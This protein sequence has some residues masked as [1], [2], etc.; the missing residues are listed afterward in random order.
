MRIEFLAEGSEDCPLILLTREHEQDVPALAAALRR[1]PIGPVELHKLPG[2]EAVGGVALVALTARANLGV[3]VRRHN[4]FE[5]VLDASGWEEVAGLLEP[6][7]EPSQEDG[8]QF[9][10]RHSGPKLVISTNGK[11]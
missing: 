1:V 3:R 10:N 11:W 8:F 2:V 5:W 9:L 7:I 6:F 4:V